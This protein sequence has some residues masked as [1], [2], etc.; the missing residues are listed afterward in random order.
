MKLFIFT[1]I[2]VYFYSNYVSCQDI[3]AGNS[4][5]LRHSNKYN[6]LLNN[7]NK[8]TEFKIRTL[9][10]QNPLFPLIKS[11]ENTVEDHASSL[12]NSLSTGAKIGIIIGVIVASIFIIIGILRCLC[13]FKLCCCNCCIK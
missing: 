6:Y 1:F 5:G 2:L 4:N 3:L 11:I 9:D 13:I 8:T 10:T 7:S 12:W